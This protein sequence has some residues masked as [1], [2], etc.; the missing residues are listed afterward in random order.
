ME[1]RNREGLLVQGLGFRIQSLLA[2]GLKG[3]M[4]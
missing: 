4:S 2:R 3:G 1:A